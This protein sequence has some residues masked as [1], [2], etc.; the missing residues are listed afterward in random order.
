MN[1]EIKRNIE[2]SILDIGGGGECV[3]GQIFG[4]KVIAIDN[5]QGELDEVPNCCEKRLMDAMSLSFDDCSFDNVTFFYS[6]MYMSKET[7]AKAIEEA[8]RVLK[9]GGSIFIWDTDIRSAYPDP[10][11]IDLDIVSGCVSIH[12]SYGILKKDPQNSDTVLRYVM[13][14]GNINSTVVKNENQFLISAVKRD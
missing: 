4:D 8:F 3:I 14:L 5:I 1:V 7:Q 2:G 12:T 13:A 6:L 11:V 9:P 10:F